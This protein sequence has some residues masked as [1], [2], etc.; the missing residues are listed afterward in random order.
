MESRGLDLAWLS[1]LP[2]S[3][4]QPALS[5]PGMLAL[6]VV[7]VM[8]VRGPVLRAWRSPYTQCPWALGPFP[9]WED[10]DQ[11]LFSKAGP[12]RVRPLSLRGSSLAV[13]LTKKTT[14]LPPAPRSISSLNHGEEKR[15]P[16]KQ[17]P[18]FIV[19][20]DRSTCIRPREHEPRFS[21]RAPYVW[22]QR[23]A[24]SGLTRPTRRW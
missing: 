3:R 19:L 8:E 15:L 17:V 6:S 4:Q 13:L 2:G 14:P 12:R 11:W 21:A 23:A 24:G 20:A 18:S 10:P 5:S 7:R 1:R 9:V 22:A 16:R